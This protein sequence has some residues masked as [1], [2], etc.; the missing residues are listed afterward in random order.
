M[1]SQQETPSERRA[2]YL[3]LAAE[4]AEQAKSASTPEL[5]LQFILIHDQWTAMAAEVEDSGKIPP[6]H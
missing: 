1:D 3:R 6:K 2:R 4:A 5:R